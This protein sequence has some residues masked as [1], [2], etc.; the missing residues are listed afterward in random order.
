MGR[1]TNLNMD[2]HPMSLTSSHP[3]IKLFIENYHVRLCHPRA[4]TFQTHK[5]IIHSKTTIFSPCVESGKC[6]SYYYQTTER[7]ITCIKVNIYNMFVRVYSYQSITPRTQV[8]FN[9]LNLSASV[10]PFLIRR[11][12]FHKI[13]SDCGTNFIGAA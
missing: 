8:R 7:S 1:L 3:L 12:S 10:H 6:Q 5:Y 11:R 9:H 4:Y 2:K 13:N